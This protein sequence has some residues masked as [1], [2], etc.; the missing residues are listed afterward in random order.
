[1]NKE[2]Y[3][4]YVNDNF[5]G[6]AKELVLKQI[7][8]FYKEESVNKNKYNIGDVV[9]LKKGTFLHGLGG[10]PDAFDWIV[11]NGF[12]ANDF[13]GRSKNK[14]FNSIGMWNIKEDCY[15]R[16][17]IKFYSGAVIKYEKEEDLVRLDIM[18]LYHLV[19]LKV[20]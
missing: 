5:E 18:M 1:M 10:N 3:I 12:I 8:L 4:E 20:I 11:D 17:Y 14:I 9:F 6:K 2:R 19:K 15:L 13:N 16:D 7:E